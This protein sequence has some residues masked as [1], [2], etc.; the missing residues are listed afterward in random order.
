MTA[1]RHF[2]PTDAH[3]GGHGAAGGQPDR[4]EA[5]S[6]GAGVLDL[7]LVRGQGGVGGDAGG[8]GV[9]QVLSVGVD[10]MGG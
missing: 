2:V 1:A 9:G 10:G 4:G 3:H 7:G 5:S 8:G 6:L